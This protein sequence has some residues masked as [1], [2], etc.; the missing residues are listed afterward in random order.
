LSQAR[1]ARGRLPAVLG[2]PVM[3]TDFHKLF[4]REGECFN[5][6]EEVKV[7]DKVDWLPNTRAQG[8][9]RARAWVKPPLAV[10]V[11]IAVLAGFSYVPHPPRR[12]KGQDCACACAHIFSIC[13][14]LRFGSDCVEVPLN[15]ATLLLYKHSAERQHNTLLPKTALSVAASLG[16]LTL[17]G[18]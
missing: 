5:E 17:S 9:H 3:G 12:W 16:G 18:T 13:S 6:V 4:D 15:L 1:R 11:E 10:G 14:Q 7:D 2:R 8:R